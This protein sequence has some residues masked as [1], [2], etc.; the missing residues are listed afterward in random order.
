MASKQI[1]EWGQRRSAAA[2]VTTQFL[3]ALGGMMSEDAKRKVAMEQE[4]GR[5]R[6][7]ATT[8][9][10]SL[11]NVFKYVLIMVRVLI[12]GILSLL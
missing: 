11:V 4:Y 1:K 7:W 2:V 10:V 5:A 6:L 3:G 12:E 8:T 9:K